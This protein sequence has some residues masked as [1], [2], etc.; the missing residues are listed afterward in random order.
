MHIINALAQ[1]KK[2]RTLSDVSCREMQHNVVPRKLY[3]FFFF[4]F[5]RGG[6]GGAERGGAGAGSV[7]ARCQWL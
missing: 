4:C 7:A 6:G 2:K 1:R 3:F 5:W